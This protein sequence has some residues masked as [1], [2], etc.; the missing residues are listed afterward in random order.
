MD[1][2]DIHSLIDTVCSNSLHVVISMDRRSIC[3]LESHNGQHIAIL[4]EEFEKLR[5]TDGR[6][7]KATDELSC[8]RSS[9][10][11]AE[12][13]EYCDRLA[14]LPVVPR[15]TYTRTHGLALLGEKFDDIEAQK[16]SENF[17]DVPSSTL[18]E[19]LHEYNKGMEAI[20]KRRKTLF[21]YTD[22]LVDNEK[23][24]FYD[25]LIEKLDKLLSL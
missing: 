1:I 23:I 6:I 5:P 16:H 22:E 14:A 25:S 19:R 9:L 24:E 12:F 3:L 7:L 10:F 15:G 11:G 18:S 4:N 8:R 20:K 13:S 17:G 21:S 2:A